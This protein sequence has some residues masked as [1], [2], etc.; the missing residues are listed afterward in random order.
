MKVLMISTDRKI[1]EE[2]SAVRQR[3]VEYGGLVDELKII[4]FSSS[5]RVTSNKHQVISIPNSNI[6]LY[7]TNSKNRW[8]YIF[9][10]MKIG[11]TIFESREWKVES[12]KNEVLV[13]TQDPFETGFVGW[14]IAKTKKTKL[15]L[16]IHTD[17]MSWKFKMASVF[18]KTRAQMAMFLIMQSKKKQKRLR[19]TWKE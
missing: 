1:F 8:F 14:V 18:N 12:D 11:K 7:P 3:I 10:A 6:T 17:F 2:N 19:D 9:D 15:H 16:Q 5:T 4:I 13:T